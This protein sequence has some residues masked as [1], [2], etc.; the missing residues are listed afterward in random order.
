MMLMILILFPQYPFFRNVIF[1]HEFVQEF[2][3]LYEFKCKFSRKFVKVFFTNFVHEFMHEI[4]VI[5]YEFFGRKIGHVTNG[6]YCG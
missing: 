4:R 2:F 5:L 6:L 3:F 1:A